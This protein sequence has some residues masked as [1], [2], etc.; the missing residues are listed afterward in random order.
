M[1]WM[2]GLLGFVEGLDGHSFVAK[3]HFDLQNAQRVLFETNMLENAGGG[4]S[5]TGFSILVTPKKRQN[6]CPNQSTRLLHTPYTINLRFFHWWP[7]SSIRENGLSLSS[8][9]MLPKLCSAA[10]ALTADD[11]SRRC[12]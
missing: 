10:E 9:S 3:N 4:F 7:N 6:G 5:Q 8:N 11:P 1:T 2:L 12:L